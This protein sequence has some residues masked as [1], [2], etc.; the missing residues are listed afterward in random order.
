M[1]KTILSALV[2]SAAMSLPAF[3][4]DAHH[5][6]Q[7]GAVPIP[8]SA[9]RTM[10]DNATRMQ[11]QLEAMA[12]SKDPAEQ[13]KLL[14]EHMQTM[15]ENMMLSQQAAAPGMGCAMMGGAGPGMGMGMGMMGPGMGMMGGPGMVSPE[16]MSN[17][18]YQ[19]E[20]RMDMMQMM[21]E[22]MGAAAVPKGR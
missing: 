14:M 19:M 8:E 4:D 22:R 12:A 16:A 17:R 13:R 21:M 10:R 5:P 3:A 11:Q 9:V 6:D 1:M 20:Q 15:R 18:L 2:V 7:A